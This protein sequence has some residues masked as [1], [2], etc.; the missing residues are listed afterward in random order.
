MS[1]E[2]FT[3]MDPS[4]GVRSQTYPVRDESGT[5]HRIAGVVSDITEQHR[6]RHESK[7]RE[8]QVIQADRLASLG[9]VVAGVA[10]EINNLSSF[11]TYNV[12]LL[13]ESWNIFEPILM[14]YSKSNPGWQRN[15]L[16]FDELLHDMH[17]TIRA[18]Q[19]G[20]DRINRVVADL[21]DFARLD[22]GA[23]TKPVDVNQVVEKTLTIVGAQLRKTVGKTETHLARDLPEISGHPHKLEQVVANLLLNASQAIPSKW[24]GRISILTRYL[25]RLGGVM[26]EVEDNG[27]GM[28]RDVVDRIFDP[29]FTTRRERGGTGLGLSVSYSLVQEHHGRLGVLSRPGLGSRF[30]VYLPIENA[31]KLDL[32]PTILCV[33]SKGNLA[34]NLQFRLNGNGETPVETISDPE[35]I[36]PYM[37]EHPEVDIVVSKIILPGMGGWDPVEKIKPR[38][39]LVAL[40]LLSNYPEAF[41]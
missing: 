34:K 33:D 39:P 22:E 18:I 31:A 27:K 29:F 26:I 20:S 6:L 14:G 10:H 8:Q 12:P 21:K 19:S 41:K 4:A 13:K 28:A 5:V 30:T 40:I 17:E 2:S 35:R 23:P 37:E 36:I 9:Q 24:E 38:F 7:L 1:T 32:R 16:S 3:R 11:I 15:G 25:D